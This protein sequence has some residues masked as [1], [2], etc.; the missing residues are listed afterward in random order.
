MTNR[1]ASGE[2]GIPST[3]N[4][5]QTS[6]NIKFAHSALVEA[7]SNVSMI[8]T[9]TN[10][11]IQV[12]NSGAEEML[13]YSREEVCRKETP[14]LFHDADEITA[15]AQEFGLSLEDKSLFDVF[16]FAAKSPN[17]GYR[18][19]RYIRK[20]KQEIRV[21]LKLSEVRNDHNE[22][23]GYL[24]VAVDVTDDLNTQ[25]KLELQESR[26]RALFEFSPVG[27]ALNDFE[28]GQFLDGNEK[29]I[30]PSGY[31]AEEFKK[32]SYYDLTPEEYFESEK[33]ML[34]ALRQT[35]R[36]GP[37][38]KEYIRKDGTRYPVLLNGILVTDSS[39]NQLIWSIVEDISE[40]KHVEEMKTQ[41]ISTVSHEL[42][43]P[44]T[45]IAG[46]LSLIKSGKFGE[47]GE[48]NS[49]MIEI[50]ASN[51]KRLTAL[52][53][54]LLDFEK[55]A[56]GNTHFNL[57]EHNLSELLKSSIK[58]NSTYASEKNI[59]ISLCLE[60][61][62][63][64]CAVNVD[65]ERFQQVMN[66]L[67]SNA[68][69]FSPEEQVVEVEAVEHPSH[70][71][72]LVKDHGVGIDEEFKGR[73]F[74]RFQQAATKDKNAT[75]GT[76]LGLAITKELLEAMHGKISFVSVKGQGSCFYFD[77]PL[78]S[79]SD[80]IINHE[81]QKVG[82][83]FALV[84]EDD[85]EACEV[86]SEI[87][88]RHGFDVITAHS[89]AEARTKIDELSF[90]VISLDLILPDGEGL[91]FLHEIRASRR[92]SQAKVI[93][94]SG[95][96]VDT[97]Q[98]NQLKSTQLDWLIKPIE[99]EQLS[100]AIRQLI[101]L[102]EKKR[103][104]HVEDDTDLSVV[105]ETILEGSFE[106]RNAITLKDAR[107]LLR[108]HRFDLILLDLAL[109]DGCGADLIP[110]IE[111][112][113]GGIPI[114]VLSGQNVNETIRKRLADVLIKTDLLSIELDEKLRRVLGFQG[115]K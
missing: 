67:L 112:T 2:N 62:Q 40:R 10:G 39:G 48:K 5:D 8:A 38:E 31:T 58:N 88:I 66:N 75:T 80:L 21:V 70:V 113:Q 96:S 73:I 68:L 23:I 44:L 90:S 16:K 78:K 42:R 107:I 43:T 111:S 108:N 6:L 95:K 65:E 105:V 93:I 92:N 15:V 69:K 77:L 27:I 1:D 91:N 28:T 98:I 18:H 13:G 51:S 102:T 54:D 94:L 84:I 109:P 115:V 87:Y 20:D 99:P 25:K 47:L 83:D 12:F 82:T 97:E 81:L 7:A 114:V 59:R 86:I 104:L 37:F 9:D 41:F 14:L 46:A 76:G 64:S 56:S 22:I 32:L 34:E 26:L 100:G 11:Y 50:A 101:D 106:Y 24:G 72:V 35:G 110:Y 4:A 3:K 52:I 74:Q 55:L 63:E 19:W 29:L 85:L 33:Q 53:N 49:K 17:F 61:V 45:S 30:E 57:K 79:G 89:I 71:R 60:S 36:Y 103:I